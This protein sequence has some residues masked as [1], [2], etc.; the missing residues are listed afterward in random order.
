VVFSKLYITISPTHKMDCTW[1]EWYLKSGFNLG[2][3]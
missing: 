1:Q 2:Q 3:R